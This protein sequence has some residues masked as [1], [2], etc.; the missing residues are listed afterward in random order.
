MTGQS[1]LGGGGARS[2]LTGRTGPLTRDVPVTVTAPAAAPRRMAIFAVVASALVM[3]TVDSTIVATALKA[4]QQG[5]HASITWTSWVITAYSVGLVL[6]L[7]LS[8]KL[9]ARFGSRRCFLASVAVFAGASLCCGF[10]GNVY[11]LIALRAVQA[12]GG[13]G[14]TPAGTAIVAAT[15]G[16]GRDKALGMFS[17]MFS[18]GTLIGPI[19]G[20]LFVTYWS[21]RGIFF[22]NVPVGIVMIAACVR[23]VPADPARPGRGERRPVDLTGLVLLGAGTLA[24]ML[25]ISYLGEAG[26]SA[27]SALF[28]GPLTAG[29]AALAL[30]GLHIRR[31]DD[32]FIAPQLIAGRGFGA[33][34]VIN[35]LYGGAVA[36]MLALVPLYAMDRYHVSVLASGTLL[37]AEGIAVIALSFV[38]TMTLRRT[39][40]RW[41][42]Y[43]GGALTALGVAALAVQP[44][45]ISP[46]AWLALAAAAVGAG[47]GISAPAGRNA[48]LQLAPGRAADL[49][50]L[51]STGRSV[52][53]IAA[54]SITAAIIAQPAPPGQLQARVFAVFAILLVASLP[55]VARIPEHRGSW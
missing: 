33:V 31:V 55:T 19:F 11:L 53:Q 28:W 25:A 4:I 51:R 9:T 12:A 14:F 13:A 35:I 21:W 32:P 44:A 41:P 5:L 43:V 22:V 49:A 7:A 40:Y 37:I 1:R 39:G 30:F 34:N 8:G 18:I 24:L 38:A 54:V 2:W 48:G 6:A 27:A 36:G 42:L 29:V 17:A 10:A 46:Y 20:G 26:A 15:F 23:Y 52:G 16:P 47:T 3:S 45:G 50:A